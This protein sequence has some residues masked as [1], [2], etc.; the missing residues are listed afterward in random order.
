MVEKIKSLSG[1]TDPKDIDQYWRELVDSR[2]RDGQP[3][4]ERRLG[5]GVARPD[6]RHHQVEGQQHR[7]RQ[8]AA[9]RRHHSRHRPC[10]DQAGRTA[11]NDLSDSRRDRSWHQRSRTQRPSMAPDHCAQ[12]SR[13][14]FLQNRKRG[15]VAGIPRCP[16]LQDTPLSFSRT[17]RSTMSMWSRWSVTPTNSLSLRQSDLDRDLTSVLENE[18]RCR[19]AGAG[20]QCGAGPRPRRLSSSV[21]CA[22]AAVGRLQADP[23][24]GRAT[25]QHR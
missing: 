2:T 18:K 6:H 1:L 15:A 19:H 17:S 21:C 16:A 3:G 11:G 5:E 23:A 22:R 8:G 7:C 20:R 4:K 25:R 12:R 24:V 14:L 13:R 10:D 9:R